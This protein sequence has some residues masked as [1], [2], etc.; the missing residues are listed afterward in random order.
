[1][2][3]CICIEPLTSSDDVHTRECGHAM[4]WACVARHVPMSCPVCRAAWTIGDSQRAATLCVHGR[5]IPASP[6]RGFVRSPLQ[7]YRPQLHPFDVMLLCCE[8]RGGPPNF[9]RLNERSMH[10]SPSQINTAG[11]LEWHDAWICYTCNREVSRARLLV[12]TSLSYQYCPVHGMCATVFDMCAGA[13]VVTQA[14]IQ[15]CG[16]HV[17]TI[18]CA[19]WDNILP[20][21]RPPTIDISDSDS[22]VDQG[23]AVDQEVAVDQ[24]V[25]EVAVDQEVAVD[26]VAEVA[27]DQ[28]VDVDMEV[29]VGTEVAEDRVAT[30]DIDPSEF[31]DSDVEAIY[32]IV[33]SHDSGQEAIDT[34]VGVARGWL[35]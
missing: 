19:G 15:Q 5:P 9:A 23:V 13:A 31:S 22:A 35:D 4:H 33:R 2:Q 24:V 34:I 32:A 6:P 14:C 25:A 29:A 28:E 11:G 12:A 30:T 17:Q 18:P 3:C 7:P 16:S 8:H 1:M 27:V 21:F 10:Y 26:E 20:D